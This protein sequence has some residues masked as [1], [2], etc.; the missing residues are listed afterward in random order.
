M[1]EMAVMTQAE[2]RLRTA[3]LRLK[4]ALAAARVVAAG[5]RVLALLGK[6]NFDPMQPR[7]PR[8]DPRGGQWTKVPG[9]HGNLPPRQRLI[10]NEPQ[11]NYPR[12]NASRSPSALRQIT[13]KEQPP[14]IPKIRPPRASLRWPIVKLVARWGFRIGVRLSPI[15]RL[16]DVIQAAQWIYEYGPYIQ[17]YLDNPRTLEEL[18]RTATEPKKGY[19]IHHIVEKTPALADGYSRTQTEAPDNLVCIPTLQHWRV[20]GWFAKPNAAY[21]GLSPR[22]Y[23]RGESWAERY[24]VGL[25]ALV[26]FEVLKP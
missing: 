20:T 21:N 2:A 18:R 16:L 22:A 13:A 15:G 19:D 7:V 6:A 17:A 8:G 23:L 3:A 14:E 25:E 4:S 9:W 12:A 11:D 26:E 24:R 5:E 1:P 10:A